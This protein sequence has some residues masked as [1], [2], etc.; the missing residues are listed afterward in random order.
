MV[1]LSISVKIKTYPHTELRNIG[2]FAQIITGQ[3][4]GKEKTTAANKFGCNPIYQ[5]YWM[6]LHFVVYFIDS[7]QHFII[8]LLNLFQAMP[9]KRTSV[10]TNE[11]TND[12][13]KRNCCCWESDFSVVPLSRP[14]DSFFF[15][16]Y[17]LSCAFINCKLTKMLSKNMVRYLSN[18]FLWFW[19]VVNKI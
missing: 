17:K 5:W 15:Y 8:L 12:P 3:T 7:T 16:W 2:I 11:R 10:R 6:S 19:Y 14:R 13:N 18:L 1:R 9:S 4:I